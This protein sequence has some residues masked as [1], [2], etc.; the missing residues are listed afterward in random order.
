M[1]SLCS[2]V[3]VCV[4]VDIFALTFKYIHRKILYTFRDSGDIVTGCNV[5]FLSLSLSL[6]HLR[7][8]QTHTLNSK[9]R[10]QRYQKQVLEQT[11]DKNLKLYSFHVRYF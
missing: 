9:K 6:S 3:C 2:K 5:I 8:K 10:N 4:H 1:S 11:H 7:I